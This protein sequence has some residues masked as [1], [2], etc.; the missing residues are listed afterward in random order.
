[1][2]CSHA[3]FEWDGAEVDRKLERARAEL[4]VLDRPARE[5]VPGRYR[6]YLEPAAL[7]EILGLLAWDGFD[8]KSHRTRQ[9]P[10]IRMTTGERRMSP[11]VHLS[12]SPATGLAPR[13]TPSGFTKAD[14]V[15]LIRGGTHGE[16]LVAPRAA[17]EYG[18]P[19]N[20]GHGFPESLEMAPGALERDAVARE[21]GTGLHLGNLWYANFS[22]RNDCRVTGMTRYACLWVEDGQVVAPIAPMRFDDSLYDLLGGHLVALTRERE[23]IVDPGTYGGRSLAS[24]RLPGVLVGEIALTL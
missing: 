5:L 11:L 22:D 16:C 6:A 4:A 10:L 15:E 12:E 9:T 17:R 21:I 19:V 13:F 1:V 18:V 3:G 2:K 20:A 8:L 7:A 24:A 23:L 14:R